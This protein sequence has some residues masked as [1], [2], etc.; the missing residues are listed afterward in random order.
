MSQQLTRLK[1]L[2]TQAW[3]ITIIRIIVF[4]SLLVGAPRKLFV[5]HFQIIYT[6][7]EKKSIPDTF[8]F[9]TDMFFLLTLTMTTISVGINIDRMLYT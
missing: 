6:A 8:A 5:Y 4:A 2:S 9:E 3:L 1:N 7:E